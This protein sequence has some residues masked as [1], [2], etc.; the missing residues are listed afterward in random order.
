MGNLICPSN[1]VYRYVCSL[2]SIDYRVCIVENIDRKSW[3]TACYIS[4][5]LISHFPSANKWG[6][7]I[8]K[9]NVHNLRTTCCGMVDH[10]ELKFYD[11]ISSSDRDELTCLFGTIAHRIVHFG[12]DNS[13][14]NNPF[15]CS[16][17]PVWP[18]AL[19]LNCEDGCVCVVS[20]CVTLSEALISTK[21]VL[22]DV[23][24]L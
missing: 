18:F 14:W 11:T 5:K 24:A 15:T 6:T 7:C 4:S 12:A 13:A 2:R 10:S 1:R 17:E 9:S 20:V 22:N 23:S 8:S 21:I 16:G 19:G 3:R